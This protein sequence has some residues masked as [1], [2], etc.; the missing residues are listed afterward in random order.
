MTNQFV[1]LIKHHTNSF[2]VAR[3]LEKGYTKALSDKF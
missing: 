3:A 1:W 2:K